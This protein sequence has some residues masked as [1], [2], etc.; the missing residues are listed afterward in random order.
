MTWEKNVLGWR[1]SKY[2]VP[3]T[4]VCLACLRNVKE[5]REMERSEPEGWSQR[6]CSRPGH[7][8]PGASER[9]RENLRK[10]WETIGP[11]RWDLSRSKTFSMWQ[12]CTELG[13]KVAIRVLAA[14]RNVEHP[15]VLMQTG[16]SKWLL[17]QSNLMTRHMNNWLITPFVFYLWF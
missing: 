10:Q 9:T 13:V 6:R 12:T 2:K 3:E 11:F 15:A 16:N 14:L 4:R 17:L 8:R 1:N 7:R 5:A